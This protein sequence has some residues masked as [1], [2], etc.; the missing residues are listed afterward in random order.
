MADK[1][2]VLS[3]LDPNS[4]SEAG[5]QQEEG[6][7]G[8]EKAGEVAK[9]VWSGMSPLEKTA[10]VTAPVPIAGDVAGL[11]ADIDMYANRP[12]ERTGLNYLLSVAGLLPFVPSRVQAKA[13]AEGIEQLAK[14]SP[15][16]RIATSK[17]PFVTRGTQFLE[18]KIKGN[19][20][21]DDLLRQIESSDL[22]TT[23]KL[24]LQEA[25]ESAQV[26][27][28]GRINQFSLRDEYEKLSPENRTFIN[29]V[30]PGPG[31]FATYD[32]LT[33]NDLGIV[34]IGVRVPETGKYF[35]EEV[36]DSVNKALDLDRFMG[37]NLLTEKMALTKALESTL[38]EFAEDFKE[39]Q[40]QQRKLFEISEKNN[41]MQAL[42][43][44]FDDLSKG[45]IDSALRMLTFNNGKAAINLRTHPELLQKEI[46]RGLI[47]DLGSN[48]TRDQ[49]REELLRRGVDPN[50]VKGHFIKEDLEYASLSYPE[51]VADHRYFDL[52]K[53]STTS[54]YT[55]TNPKDVFDIAERKFRDLIGDG[56]GVVG[57]ETADIINQVTDLDDN[58]VMFNKFRELRHVARKKRDMID[59]D[60]KVVEKE[61]RNFT[62]RFD[63]KLRKEGYMPNAYRPRQHTSL[64]I[65]DK[66]TSPM[67]IA[68]FADIDAKLAD[69]TETKNMHYAELQ[70]DYADDLRTRGPTK[71]SAAIDDAE[72]IEL[73]AGLNDNIQRLEAS[74]T[75]LMPEGDPA[76]QLKIDSAEKKIERLK[77]RA[78]RAKDYPDESYDVPELYPEMGERGNAQQVIEIIGATMGAV[79]RGKNSVSFPIPDDVASDVAKPLYNPT[80][81]NNNIREA[82]KR[83][84]KDYKSTLVEFTDKNGNVVQ[85]PGITWSPETEPRIGK[86]SIGGVKMFR[87]G[88]IIN[89]KPPIRGNSGIVDVI[90]Q[91]RRDGLMD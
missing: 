38:P 14:Q 1:Q 62:A 64:D 81:F 76:I 50:T 66:D 44:A 46:D 68:R 89:A 32:N 4:L 18:E 63:K 84:G 37:S 40:K 12:E 60:A 58:F 78:Q 41:E 74:K 91:Y 54:P 47:L 90:K 5:L 22:P 10:L 45:D 86:E 7:T 19:F 88:G 15:S 2:G 77:E 51:E 23:D 83:L 25:V 17:Q 26:D 35:E 80:K 8:L 69:G 82:V 73:E 3:A 33:G 55:I 16:G 57:P 6:F 79:Q 65:K 21:K 43:L 59:N 87:G 67:S 13:A 85:R 31:R 20:P 70:S 53:S 52:R 48:M 56:I 39:L 61:V 42:Q 27:A 49:A 34:Q 72:V 75:E 28:K 11:A 36:A 30:E 24:M 71:G 29:V 9:Q